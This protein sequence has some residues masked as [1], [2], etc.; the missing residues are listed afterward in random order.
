[1]TRRVL[2]IHRDEAVRTRLAAGADGAFAAV[3][4]ATVDEG[5]ARHGRH[6]FDVVVVELD[7]AA[8]VVRELRQWHPE[9]AIITVGDERDDV[10][11]TALASGA[12][13]HLE[14]DA[15][16][17]VVERAVRRSWRRLRA[18]RT[19]RTGHPPA[20]DMG[21]VR[22]RVGQ[23]VSLVEAAKE[24]IEIDEPPHTTVRSL[25]DQASELGTDT[26][27][28]TGRTGTGDTRT[29]LDLPG[30]IQAAWG[31]RSPRDTQLVIDDVDVEVH[32]YPSMLRT[33]L[34]VL[35]AHALRG[36]PHAAVVRVDT[37]ELSDALRLRIH[38][39]G[40]EVRRDERRLLFTGGEHASPM[41]MTVEHVAARHG[42]TAW[43]ADSDELAGGTMAVI[44]LPRRAAPR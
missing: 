3:E 32:G 23:L 40:P 30:L 15:P 9:P 37:E 20:P 31:S 26:V 36:V 44:D 41:L 7:P 11:E 18:A 17:H 33:A 14:A 4:A 10:V 13:D 28:L 22:R 2:C 29:P 6:P 42:G 21:D 35:F 39:D 1:M 12:H 19:S 8:T 38:D 27:Q 43:L 24:L 34:V 25:L 5:A 16:A